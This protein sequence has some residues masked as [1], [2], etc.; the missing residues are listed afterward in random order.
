VKGEMFVG[1]KGKI[2]QDRKDVN[3]RKVED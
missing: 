2:E 1:K 3:R